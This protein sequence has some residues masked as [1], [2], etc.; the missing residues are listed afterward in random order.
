M[1]GKDYLPSFIQAG[2]TYSVDGGGCTLS[3]THDRERWLRLTCDRLSHP[4]SSVFTPS[5][6]P[7][8]ASFAARG[9]KHREKL[10]TAAAGGIT[11]TS[12]SPAQDTSESTPKKELEH[13]K[14]KTIGL[15]CLIFTKDT[16][17]TEALLLSTKIF[18]N[19]NAIC[20]LVNYFVM[21]N[22]LHESNLALNI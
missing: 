2:A 5:G 4:H 22:T 21:N 11:Q 12:W 9:E 18:S 20:M 1:S 10:S 17:L 15:S 8:P 7:P 19:G 6:T 14:T 13:L 3:A 16:V